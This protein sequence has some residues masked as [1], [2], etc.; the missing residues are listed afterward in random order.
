MWEIIQEILKS[1][2]GSFGF[3]FAILCLLFFL[4]F[5]AGKIVEKF[6]SVTKLESNVETMKQDIMDIKAFI[7]VFRQE[8]SKFSQR[9]SPISLSE[10][11]DRVSKVINAE[12]IIARCWPVLQKE[13]KEKLDHTSNPYTIQ[14]ICF[15]IS[16]HYMDYLDSNEIDMIK[17]VAFQEGHNV[18]N[19]D[20]IFGI[21]IRDK[22]F[23]E[24]NINVSDVDKHD[25]AKTI[26]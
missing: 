12:K 11:G 3:V 14:Q 4:V 15:D 20:I 13:I 7:T 21:M 19:Y 1:P 9:R 5:R 23:K 25:P 26:K 16:K 8:N 6:S 24:N 22:Y 18:T 2:A 10:E 17:K